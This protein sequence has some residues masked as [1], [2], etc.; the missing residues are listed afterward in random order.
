MAVVV[1]SSA[2]AM[3]LIAVFVLSVSS[4]PVFAASHQHAAPAPAVDC[5]TLILNMADCLTFVSSGSS[6]AKPEDSC[7][8]GLKTV[9]RT[10]AECLCEGFK[11]S[12]SL[13]VT[14][15][16]TKTLTLPAA[17][18]LLHAPSIASC[19]LSTPPAAAP[20]LAPGAAAGPESAGS[21]G[22]APAP[23]RGNYASALVPVWVA[24]VVG[25]VLVLLFSPL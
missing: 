24:S 1:R 13:G 12:A 16:V 25:G 19:G 9:L 18:K 2:A 22:L 8:S 20:G 14:L 3:S 10:D 23:A 11:S 6:V 17:C 15:N 21:N 7:C 4:A 5:S